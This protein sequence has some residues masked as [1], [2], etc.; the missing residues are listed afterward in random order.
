MPTATYSTP[1]TG[2]DA[3]MDTEPFQMS[4]GAAVAWTVVFSLMIGTAIAANLLV[5]W[6]VL[7]KCENN[8]TYF[9]L[10]IY[11]YYIYIYI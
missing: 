11:I 8:H 10:I 5:L 2:K 7:G 6:I 1:N 9:A 4:S 3:E